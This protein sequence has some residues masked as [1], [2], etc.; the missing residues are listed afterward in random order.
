M[1]RLPM[2]KLTLALATA[3]VLILSAPVLAKPDHN[4]SQHLAEKLELSSDQQV[5]VSALFEA[6][7]ETIRAEGSRERGDRREARMALHAEIRELLNTEQAEQFD[8][9]LQRQQRGYKGRNH[10]DHAGKGGMFQALDL[11]DEQRSELR[12]LMR[13]HRDQ[14]GAGRS[15]LREQ[16]REILTEEQIAQLEAARAERGQQRGGHRRNRSQRNG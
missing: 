4:P 9:L 7:R 14:E 12:T 6:H 10:R 11:S 15:E 13:E 5:Q 8:N 16:M 1:T 2:K 3:G